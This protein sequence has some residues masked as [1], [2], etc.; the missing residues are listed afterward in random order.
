M[1]C[2]SQTILV[3][4]LFFITSCKPAPVLEPGQTLELATSAENKVEVTIALTR[5]EDGQFILSATFTPQL[6]GAHLYSKEIPRNGVDGLGRPTLLELAEGSVLKANGE[7]SEST[8]SAQS[9]SIDPE[10]LQ[11]YPAGP[12]TLSMPVLLPNGNNWLNDE[13]LVTY[14]V[15][16]GQGCRAPVQQKPIA[17][18]IPGNG[19]FQ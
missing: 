16:D 15:C 4:I 11:L 7:L 6:L 3:F 9:S 12:V 8:V 10:G 5:S 14:M 19:L 17:I 2:I 13:V 1:K 18:K